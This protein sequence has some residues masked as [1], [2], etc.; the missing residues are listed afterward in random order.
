MA[1]LP[2][3]KSKR[4]PTKKEL[5][6]YQ[7]YEVVDQTVNRDNSQEAILYKGDV[8]QS[9]TG[10]V[11]VKFTDME[12]I[13]RMPIN[14]TP[15]GSHVKDMNDISPVVSPTITT[16]PVKFNIFD[17]NFDGDPQPQSNAIMQEASDLDLD[18]LIDIPLEETKKEKKEKKERVKREKKEKKEREK[19]EK[20]KEKEERKKE[21]PN[22]K[23]GFLSKIAAKVLTPKASPHLVHEEKDKEN[24]SANVASPKK[25]KSK[26]RLF[27]GKSS[28]LAMEEEGDGE[29]MATKK[30]KSVTVSL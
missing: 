16:E 30:R 7:K 3:G 26:R 19:E 6:K 9:I 11:N 12:V 23:E 25:E 15:N 24:L 2:P 14:T 4:T 21:T 10:G 22:G 13:T 17:D 27:S 29:E 18:D 20:K 8:E 5:K 1:P 28:Q